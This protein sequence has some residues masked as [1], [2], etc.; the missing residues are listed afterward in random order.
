MISVLVH[1]IQM[2]LDV[3]KKMSNF[4]QWWHLQACIGLQV[5]S[6]QTTDGRNLQAVVDAHAAELN[7][8]KAIVELLI[9]KVN[10]LKTTV[11]L[12]AQVS[13]APP[14]YVEPHDA[15]SNSEHAIKTT[16]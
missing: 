14:A 2:D 5:H 3:V 12:S 8:L 15:P 9:A 1:E 13:D 11:R 4:A 7:Q 10:Q 6:V 16:K